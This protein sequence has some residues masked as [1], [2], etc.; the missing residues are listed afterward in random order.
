MAFYIICFLIVQVC[1]SNVYRTFSKIDFCCFF[2]TSGLYALF[3]FNW[4]SSAESDVN[5]TLQIRTWKWR[6]KKRERFLVSKVD[7]EF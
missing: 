5:S 6:K 2:T 1:F 3:E 7:F 4:N